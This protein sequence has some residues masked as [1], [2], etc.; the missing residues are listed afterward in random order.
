MVFF[1][2]KMQQCQSPTQPS[3]PSAAGCNHPFLTPH[4]RSI[5]ADTMPRTRQP[6]SKVCES[7][8]LL[9]YI[10]SIHRRPAPLR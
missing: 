4:V 2:D 7:L 3:R 5:S 8:D 6:L 9:Q 10:Q 1:S